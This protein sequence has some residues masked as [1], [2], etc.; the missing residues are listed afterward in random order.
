MAP[1]KHFLICVK[2]PVI[3]TPLLKEAVDVA[4]VAAAFGQ[5]VSVLFEGDGIYHCLQHQE[6]E[7]VGLKAY[8]KMLGALALY[9]I[10]TVYICAKSARDRAVEPSALAHDFEWLERAAI[11]ELIERSEVVIDYS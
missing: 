8:Q 1:K 10:D 11:I 3:G 7:A 2:S 5:P 4:M 6:P 9:D